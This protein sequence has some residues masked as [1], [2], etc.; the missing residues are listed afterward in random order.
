MFSTHFVWERRSLPA[1]P[2][3][4]E[5]PEGT[6]LR[7]TLT[8]A[9]DS[10]AAPGSDDVHRFRF[11]DDGGNTHYVHLSSATWNDHVKVERIGPRRPAEVITEA[12]NRCTLKAARA[13]DALTIVDALRRAGMLKE[14]L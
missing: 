4:D 11:K 2:P 12:I 3:S 9:V 8:G 10:T 6:R 13:D 7:V 1:L 14:G 5:Y